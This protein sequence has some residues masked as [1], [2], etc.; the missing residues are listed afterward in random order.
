MEYRQGVMV[1]IIDKRYSKGGKA[2]AENS[3]RTSA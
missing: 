3:K 1:G 2:A